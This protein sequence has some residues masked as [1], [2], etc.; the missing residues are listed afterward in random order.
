[1]SILCAGKAHSGSVD[2]RHQFL[3]VLHQHSIEQS[4]IPFLDTH[5]VDIPKENKKKEGKKCWQD[6]DGKGKNENKVLAC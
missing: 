5:Q 4:L 3:D 1:M 2:D 6:S